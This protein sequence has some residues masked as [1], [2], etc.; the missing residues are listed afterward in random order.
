M[1]TSIGGDMHE[2]PTRDPKSSERVAEAVR[3]AL[4]LV[5]PAE[6]SE[7]QEADAVAE[8]ATE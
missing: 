4:L 7:R 8:P 3:R 6:S 2:Q 5:G 1:R